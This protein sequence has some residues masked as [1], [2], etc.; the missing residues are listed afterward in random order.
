[1]ATTATTPRPSSARPAETPHFLPAVQ[2]LRALAV[3]LVVVFHAG[4]P[5]SGGFVGVDVFFVVSGFVITRLLLRDSASA[6]GIR[7]RQ[8]YLRR[9][10]RLL[11]AAALMVTVTVVLAAVLQTPAAAQQTGYAAL[12]S[13]VWLA[14]AAL[15]VLTAGY[16][17]FRANLIPLEHMWSL[18]VEEQFYFVFPLLTVAALA[19]AR[20]RARLRGGA[21]SRRPLAWVI[22]LVLVGSFLVSLLLSYGLAPLPAPEGLAYYAPFS[23]AW[24][25][26]AGALV[27]LL[28]AS[29][30]VRGQA[31]G[32][33]W[34]GVGLVLIL[35]SAVLITPDQAFPGIVAIVPLLGTALVLAVLQR[36]RDGGAVGRVLASRPA[37]WLGDRSY[38]WY[39]WHWPLIAFA[40]IYFPRQVGA[41][42]IAAALSLPVAM[43]AY[44]WV[45]DPIRRR[46]ER[47]GVGSLRLVAV[48]LAVPMALSTVVVAGASQSWGNRQVQEFRAQVEPKSLNS[49][50]CLTRRPVST[51]DLAAC[52]VN[53]DAPGQ[54]LILV[55][56][57]N[58]ASY[59]DGLARVAQDEDRPLVIAT[60]Q[61]CPFL[62]VQARHP[63]Y[64]W[65]P[66]H[67]LYEDTLAWLDTQDPAL[68]VMA[69][70][71]GWVD[72]D[73]TVMRDPAT[74]A[75]ATTAAERGELWRAGSVRTYDALAAAG[76][77]VVQLSAVPHFVFDDGRPWGPEAC[78]WSVSRDDP[79]RCGTS[80][81]RSQA[82]ADQRYGLQAERTAAREAGVTYVDLRRE[83]CP[84]DVCRTNDGNTW[85]YRDGA[86]LSVGA[87]LALAP[88]LA[89]AIDRAGSASGSQDKNVRGATSGSE[90]GRRGSGS[91]DRPTPGST[92][93]TPGRPAAPTPPTRPT[94]SA[95]SL[96][97]APS[98]PNAPSTPGVPAV[99]GT[100]TIPEVPSAP[101][102]PDL[103][104]PLP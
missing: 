3:L 85:I 66:C 13:A 63:A 39:L 91:G 23:R 18:A 101:T 20:R 41:S 98:L 79:S 45:E 32:V 44:S 31:S 2:G 51:R 8:F 84:E 96:Q 94:P 75:S 65:G 49:H 74:G 37:V 70:A 25:F 10:R 35:V 76:H 29:R 67:R 55:G 11:P 46:R 58:A 100:P 64:N 24:E 52:T 28:P 87:S 60:A 16:F 56:D 12:A 21:V 42:V 17:S 102:L 95:P 38:S 54:P 22:A 104:D 47:R 99:P 48:C 61:G 69:S 86:H 82:D 97:D 9:F 15:F 19:W 50:A 57:S 90:D 53:A 88:V 4:L 7:L 103:R 89:R 27:A 83:V 43:A 1:M 5:L 34:A 14:N 6:G 33:G 71:N 78:S 68:V 30:S 72:L 40:D 62:D 81:T 80:L 77:T 92:P 73:G 26:A 36:G 59:A 93:G